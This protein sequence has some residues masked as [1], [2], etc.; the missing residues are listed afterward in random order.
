MILTTTILGHMIHGS[1][2]LHI[3]YGQIDGTDGIGGTDLIEAD[4]MWVGIVGMVGMPDITGVTRDG[5]ITAG[6][7]A[8][9]AGIHGDIT[10][11]AGTMVGVVGITTMADTMPVRDGAGTTITMVGT[12]GVTTA[13]MEEIETIGPATEEATILEP[14]DIQAHPDIIEQLTALDNK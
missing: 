2:A 6:I 3:A 7:M 10:V 8:G 12:H 11:V 9:V 1:M 4:G 5:A 13:G 14:E